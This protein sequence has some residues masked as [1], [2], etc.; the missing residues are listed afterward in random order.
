MTTHPPQLGQSQQLVGVRSDTGVRLLAVLDEH[1]LVVRVMVPEVPSAANVVLLVGDA[2]V[3]GHVLGG[4]KR[5]QTAA[6]LELLG[7]V[8]AQPVRGHFV[9]VRERL[10]ADVARE[11]A[12]DLE[13]EGLV[14]LVF[15]TSGDSLTLCTDSMWST[16]FVR[17][18]Y[19]FSQ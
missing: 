12:L 19:R 10:H 13:A 18:G 3:A 6:A 7:V 5:H 14:S 1:V 2:Q 4:Q 17:L 8:V 16:S 11:A 9:R 15:T